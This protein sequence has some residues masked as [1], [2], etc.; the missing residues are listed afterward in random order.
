MLIGEVRYVWPDT[1]SPKAQIQF[2]SFVS[3]LIT[4]GM[5]AL[6]RWVLK[7]DAE[8]HIGVCI[9]QQDF[10]GEDRKLDLMYWIKLPFADD[11]HKFW[12]PS[13]TKYKTAAG[14]EVTEH[15]FIPTKEQCDLMDS[16]VESMDLDNVKPPRD[17]D[18][19]EVEE[20]EGDDE[21]KEAMDVDGENSHTWFDPS[22][23][24]NPV[25][26]RIKEAIFHASL[27]ADPKA[28]PLGPPHPDIIKYFHTPEVIAQKVEKLTEQLKEALD[29]KKIPPRQRK[30][31]VR[32]GLAEDEG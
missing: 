12:F 14:K 1:T 28:N 17:D 23:C 18:Q 31:F 15:P 24:V 32:E 7:D 20:E 25:I 2:S 16:L 4:T 3:A 11:D 26:H 27:T 13:L 22:L 19:D 29:I 6:V 5:A 30:K 9:P 10:P 21:D 8:P